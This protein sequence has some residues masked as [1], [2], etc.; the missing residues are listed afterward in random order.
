MSQEGLTDFSPKAMIR[1]HRKI[2]GISAILLPYK[3]NYEIDWPGLA[4]HVGGR[5]KRA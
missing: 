1:P 3:D 4:A 5:R 2:T